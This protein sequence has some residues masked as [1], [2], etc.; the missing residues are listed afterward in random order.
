VVR[1]KPAGHLSVSH[2][3]AQLVGIRSQLQTGA[4]LASELATDSVSAA[5][6]QTK[7]LSLTER[8]GRNAASVAAFQNILLDN[9]KAIREAIS[10]GQKTM[11]D[12][13]P[14]LRQAS[15]FKEWT[16]DK[17]DDA[18]L[19]RNYIREV[20]AMSWLDRLPGRAARFAL[21]TGGGAALDLAAGLPIGLALGL[22]DTFILDKLVRGWRP[23]QFIED[24]LVLLCQIHG[25]AS[26]S[27]GNRD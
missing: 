24:V 11:R 27:D 17:S 14:I 23:N 25:F 12:L 1:R 19:L 18:D 22:A 3:L 7:I 16:R 9:A 20:T 8:R 5:I 26:G 15:K 13:L 6:M 10:T 21:F 2:I 4:S